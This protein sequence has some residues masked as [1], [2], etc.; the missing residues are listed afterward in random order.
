ML[1]ASCD[2]FSVEQGNKNILLSSK[3]KVLYLLSEKDMTPAD[4]IQCLG[5]AKSNLANLS[6]QLIEEGVME[7]Y[8]TLDNMR[9][10]YY[11]ITTTGR[12]ELLSYKNSLSKLFCEKY[13]D[14][15]NDLE[16]NI[17]KILSILKKD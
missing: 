3:I 6:K 13:N 11:R 1:N 7:S 4:L 5:M 15:I 8:K 2:G 12:E 16:V 9:N 10:V 17:D 14:N